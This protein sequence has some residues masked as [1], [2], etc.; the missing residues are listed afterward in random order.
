MNKTVNKNQ[1]NVISVYSL[2]R[3]YLSLTAPFNSPQVSPPYLPPH[4]MFAFCHYLFILSYIYFNP[5]SP[6]WATHTHIGVGPC[7]ELW[8]RDSDHMPKEKWLPL[9]KQPSLTNISSRAGSLR[10]PPQTAKTIFVWKT[11]AAMKLNYLY[12][13]KND[14]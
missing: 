14:V 9:P 8:E 2:S 1:T 7:T 6:V 10:A 3:S 4:F 5:L 11:K 12:A 13:N